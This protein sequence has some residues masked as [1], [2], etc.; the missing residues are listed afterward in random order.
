MAPNLS[1]GVLEP[2]HFEKMK[3]SSSMHVF[4]KSTSA[5]LRYMVEKERKPESFLTTSWFLEKMDHWFELMSSRNVVTALSHFKIEVYEKAISFL[6]DLIHLFQELKIGPLETSP[7][8]TADGHNNTRGQ[9]LSTTLSGSYLGDASDHL[10]DFLDTQISSSSA[11]EVVRVE[12]LV[13]TSSCVLYHLAGYIVK[14]F[15]GFK[16]C[17][18]CQCALVEK[19]T[20]NARSGA[21]VPFTD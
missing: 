11:S 13:H 21:A 19:V 2:S 14:S 3:V 12:Q 9:F 18:E 6:R 5:A 15:I 20:S 16:L 1:R 4:S 8:R 10:A 17:E 7:D